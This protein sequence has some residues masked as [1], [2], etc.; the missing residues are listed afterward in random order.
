MPASP[1]SPHRPDDGAALSFASFTLDRRRGQLTNAGAPVPLR[2]K[3]WSVLVYLAERPG[4][5]VTREELLDAVWPDVAVTPD[6]LTKSIGELRIALGDDSRQP[7]FIETVH[8]RGFRFLDTPQPLAAAAAAVA[9]PSGD[10]P[11]VGRAAELQRLA[12]CLT[13]ARRGERQMVF[14]SGQAG[15]GKTA[16]L[17]TFLRGAAIAQPG[18]VVATGACITHHGEHEAYLPVLEAVERLARGPEAARVAAL[19]RGRAPS[20][21]AQMPWLAGEDAPPPPA[22]RPERML[23]EGVALL[24]GLAGET[25]VVVVLEDLHWSDPSTVD[26]LARL[27]QRREPARLLVLASYRPADVA[28]HEHPLGNALRMLRGLRRCVDL[29]LHELSGE[30]VL[31]YLDAR[32]P[33]AALPEGLAA[34]LHHHTDG[35]P[36][37]LR[38]VVDH[39]VARGWILDTAPGWSFAALPSDAAFGVPDDA[40][41][42]I[43]LQIDSLAP[44]D[45][46]V[47]EAAGVAGRDASVPLLAAVLDRDE[48]AVEQSCETLA[49]G[50]RFLRPAGDAVAPRYDFVHELYRQAIYRE[51]PAARRQR[52]HRATAAALEARLGNRA[53]EQAAVLAHHCEH[54]GDARRAITY[55]CAAAG[56]ARRRGAP[57]EAGGHLEH[58]L[59]LL[60]RV[61]PDEVRQRE[62]DIRIAMAHVEIERSGAASAALRDVCERAL[63]LCDA[64]EPGLRF[65]VLSALCHVRT[66]RGDRDALGSA[67]DALD[68]TANQL[69]PAER[70][71]AD[72]MLCRIATYQTRYAE[73]CEFAE[74]VFAAAAAGVPR[75]DGFGVDPVIACLNHRAIATWLLGQLDA[76]RA[77]IRQL[78]VESAAAPSF[79]R[80]SAGFFFCLLACMER[81]AA[82]ILARSPDLLALADEHGFAQW[83][84]MVGALR[85]WA[86]V[87]TGAVKAGLATLVDA[88]AAHAEAG[89]H[90]FGTLI[91]AMLAEA[92]G[93]A[94]ER[95]AGLATVVEALR[96]ADAGVDQMWLSEL[97]RVRGELL[98]A[99]GATADGEAALRQA[100]EIARAQTA[101]MLALRASLALAQ[102]WAAG[103]RAAE[104]RSLLEAALCGIE[105][106]AGHPD[107]RAAHALLAT[108][109][110]RRPARRRR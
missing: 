10:G 65:A 87:E 55:L 81:D 33:G 54:G 98:C 38:A 69:G 51:T 40:R 47:L 77:A 39:L 7:R 56:T 14:V 107:L 83:L 27:A 110:G 61:P 80:V 32:F 17:E 67:V 42:M 70:L 100:V 12:G 26:L 90:T 5:L 20:W 74:R 57:R 31:A 108:P 53:A 45:R 94:G 104:A 8:R 25:T 18:T 44:A 35:H 105:G 103:G 85:G 99:G 66:M 19:L 13:A 102:R 62:L 43:G 46:R 72:S 91:L 86:Q 93:R 96:I 6:T 48:D 28:V 97:W 60:P 78:A 59:A 24:E 2:P 4:T 9:A 36:L 84:P 76:A 3:T 50:E 37:F 101:R 29:P 58:A 92:Q 89:T 11:F 109:P 15:V 16:L 30:A 22:A 21:L 63:A 52:L 34:A 73:A 64:A 82:Q 49:R 71:L 23:R 68:A 41:D 88:R 95:D 75:V 106:G 79:G 1:T